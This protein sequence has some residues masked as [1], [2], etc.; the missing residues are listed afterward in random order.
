MHEITQ[1]ATVKHDTPKVRTLRRA[2]QVLGSETKLAEALGVTREKLG[3]WLSGEDVPDDA[4]YLISLDIVVLG[5]FH[6]RR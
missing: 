6:R 3:R 2:L 5:N 4:A 1:A